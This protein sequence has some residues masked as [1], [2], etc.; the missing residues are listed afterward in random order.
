MALRK[1]KLLGLC[2]NPTEGA[3]AQSR[4]LLELRLGLTRWAIAL[5]SG[6]VC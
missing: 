3:I 6:S 2:F 1:I 5:I 4:F